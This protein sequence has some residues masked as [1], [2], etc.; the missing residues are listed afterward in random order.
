MIRPVVIIHRRPFALLSIRI[1]V[2][3]GYL[4][5]IITYNS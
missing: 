1:Y 5:L 3:V 2:P 4:M